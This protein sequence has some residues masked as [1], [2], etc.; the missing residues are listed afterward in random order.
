M[1]KLNFIVVILIII[2]GLS[3]TKEEMS[4]PD[5]SIENYYHSND[6]LIIPVDYEFQFYCYSS[7]NNLSYNWDF[8]DNSTSELKSPTHK[9]IDTGL[10][11]VTLTVQNENGVS[12]S[13]IYVKV[14]GSKVSTGT[15]DFESIFIYQPADLTLYITFLKVNY[16]MVILTVIYIYENFKIALK[17]VKLN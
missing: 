14:C 16:T 13:Q 6:T 4:P 11:N 1:F 10:Y 3:C 8:D 7:S 17:S 12:E 2:I 5:I 15:T 9:F